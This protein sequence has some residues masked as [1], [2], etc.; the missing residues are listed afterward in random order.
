MLRIALFLGTNLAIVLL[1]SLVFRLFGIEGLL[2]E[3]GVDL[4]LTA[5]IIFSA[6]IGFSGSLISL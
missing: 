1:I 4:D 2:K 6:L 3:N 5:L